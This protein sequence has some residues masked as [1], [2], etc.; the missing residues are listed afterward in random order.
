MNFVTS[1]LISADWKGNSYNL[2]LV[3]VDWLIKMVHYKPI[4][5][6]INASGLA[7][8]IIDMIMQHHG[9]PESIVID[10]SLLLISKFWSSLCYFIETKKKLSIAFYSQ[11]N[12]QTKRQNNIIKLYLNVFVNWK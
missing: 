3:I 6:T 2:I 11:T 4:K 12:G 8:V 9:V 5:V 7:K 10:Q 1:F